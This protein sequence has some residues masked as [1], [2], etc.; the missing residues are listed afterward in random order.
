MADCPNCNYHLKITDWKPNCPKCGVNVLYAEFEPRFYLDAKKAELSIASVR[1]WAKQLVA[2]LWGNIWAKLRICLCFLPAAALLL[3][4]LTAEIELPYGGTSFSAGLLGIVNII[5]GG[6]LNFLLAFNEFPIPGNAVTFLYALLGLTV[7]AV[8]LAVLTLFGS[9]FS[10]TKSKRASWTVFVF[11]CL[12]FLASAAAFGLSF[13]TNKELLAAPG[14]ISVQL[15]YGPILWAAMFGGLGFIHFMA[16]H[17]ELE[18]VYKEGD[19]ER[20]R[21][22][23]EVKTGKTDIYSLPYPVVETAET[24]EREEKINEELIALGISPALAAEAKAEEAL[25]AAGIDPDHAEIAKE[26]TDNG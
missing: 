16:A 22:W 21:I 3:P 6:Q 13:F 7:V 25:A 26:D 14:L 5:T 1:V 18:P 9:L 8:L 23:K 10:F 11:C 4:A 20:S 24:R 19:Y 2:G 15:Q 17:Q 12:G